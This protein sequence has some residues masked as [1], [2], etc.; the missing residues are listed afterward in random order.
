MGISYNPRIITD[1][2]VLCLDAANR[3]S[4]PGSGTTW[5]DLSGIPS[6]PQ[7]G[8]KVAEGGN[9]TLTAP[10]G[11]VITS[12][13]FASYGTPTGT[14]PNFSIGGCHASNSVSVVEGLAL[15][16]NSVTISASNDIFGDPCVGTPKELAVV[17]TTNSSSTAARFTLQ[18]GV[19]YDSGNLG[20][21]T[22]D[23]VDDRVILPTSFLPNQL[24]AD[25]G[26]SWTVSCWFKFPISP[27]GTKT[28][29]ASWSLIG[30]AGGIGTAG[31]FILFVGSATDT[32]FGQYAPYKLA[33]VIRGAVTVISSSSVNTNTYNYVSLTWN[34]SS[35][36]VYFN[37]Q[38][39]ASMNVGTAVQQVY[40]DFYIG[41]NSN[42]PENHYYSGNISQVSIYNRALTAQEISQNYNALRSRFGI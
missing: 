36:F 15:G 14:F 32:T 21:L 27:V 40:T 42:A 29:N 1:G 12:I 18:N 5:F 10:L 33:S 13:D 30:R 7:I 34:G 17:A 38:S 28:S 8:G 35:G 2:L 25:N 3:K 6:I 41:S 39:P 26:G 22:F 31:H 20:S 9:L 37:N 16:Q 4:Y 11:S 23:G 24:F 19:G